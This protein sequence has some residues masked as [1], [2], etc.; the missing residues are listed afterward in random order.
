MLSELSVL[1][2]LDEVLMHDAITR[3]VNGQEA[4]GSLLGKPGVLSGAGERMEP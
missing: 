2:N 3:T 4:E 1:L